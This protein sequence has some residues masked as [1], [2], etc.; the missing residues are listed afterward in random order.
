MHN[1]H[2]IGS[3]HSQKIFIS[4]KQHGKLGMKGRNFLIIDQHM[5]VAC[6]M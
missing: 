3:R 1:L 4:N 2:D 5:N 6:R